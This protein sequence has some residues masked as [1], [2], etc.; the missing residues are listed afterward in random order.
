LENCIEGG[1]GR[2]ISE[3][4]KKY[5]LSIIW[6]IVPKKKNALGKAVAKK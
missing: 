3:L 4:K 1:L 2:I 5:H 6:H